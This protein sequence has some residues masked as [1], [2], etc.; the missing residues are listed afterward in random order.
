MLRQQPREEA[1]IASILILLETEQLHRFMGWPAVRCWHREARIGHG[2]CDFVLEH[3]D[4]SHTLL[5]AKAER[6]RTYIASA[7]G[8]LFLY[9]AGYTGRAPVVRKALAVPGY[10]DADVVAACALADVEFIPLGSL[11]ERLQRYEQILAKV[12]QTT[13]AQV[14]G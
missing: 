14:H 13:H 4:G 10:G 7:I 12:R 11:R 2:R 5:E 9:H 8:Q 6:D 1:A 3:A